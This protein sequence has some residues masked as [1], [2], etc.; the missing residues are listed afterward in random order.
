MSQKHNALKFKRVRNTLMSC[1]L[2]EIINEAKCLARITCNKL[3]LKD[4][5]EVSSHPHFSHA[6]DFM[7]VH[8]IS[9]KSEEH[10]RENKKW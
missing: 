1:F 8:V 5:D 7:L 4:D 10:H 6:F 9:N 2:L 3:R